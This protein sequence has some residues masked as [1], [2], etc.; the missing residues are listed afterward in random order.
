MYYSILTSVF[1]RA[2]VFTLCK[3]RPKISFKLKENPNNLEEKNP[4]T[5]ALEKINKLKII[6]SRGS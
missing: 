5:R 3:F 4:T 1:V 6:I 2:R